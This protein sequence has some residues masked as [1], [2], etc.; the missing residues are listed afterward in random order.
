[1]LYSLVLQIKCHYSELLLLL[2][3]C[4]LHKTDSTASVQLHLL[5]VCVQKDRTGQR[6]A[7][8]LWYTRHFSC[9]S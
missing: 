9:K 5:V 8:I 2:Q 4:K 7:R 3:V 1:M 6:E